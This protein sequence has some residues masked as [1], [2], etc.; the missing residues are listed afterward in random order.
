MKPESKNWTASIKPTLLELLAATAHF[1]W[2]DWMKYMLLDA[3]TQNPD[4][5]VT[6]AADKVARWSRQMKTPY[7]ALPDSE[8]VSDREEAR[9]LIKEG[10]KGLAGLLVIG[11]NKIVGLAEKI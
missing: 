8:K 4:G 6:I 5:S 11:A 7:K 1:I 3:A 2:S 10:A 9:R